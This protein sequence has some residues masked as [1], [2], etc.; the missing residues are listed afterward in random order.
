MGHY[1][2]C[3]NDILDV[4]NIDGMLLK[5]GHDIEIGKLSWL[6]STCMERANDAQKRIMIDN[7]GQKGKNHCCQQKQN[8]VSLVIQT[9]SSS[10]LRS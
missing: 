5:P 9:F 10:L 4:F 6:S 3:Q 1:H 2:Q 7:Y 8:N